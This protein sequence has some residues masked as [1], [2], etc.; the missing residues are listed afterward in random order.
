MNLNVFNDPSDEKKSRF[1]TLHA[2]IKTNFSWPSVAPNSNTLVSACVLS[3]SAVSD[4][5]TPWTVAL[6]APL[7]VGFSTQDYWSG[8][9]CPP[10]GDL[11]GPGIEPMSPMPLALAGKFFTTSASWDAHTG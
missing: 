5:A 7:S 2:D 10:P 11:P 4:S 3:R 6:Q 1:L 8:F 9:P